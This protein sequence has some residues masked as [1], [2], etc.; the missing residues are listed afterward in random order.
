MQTFGEAAE[1]DPARGQVIDDGEDVLGVAPES[2]QLPDGKDVALA[3]VVEAGIEMWPGRGR[4]ADVV[5]EDAL[6]AGLEEGIDLELGIL[7]GVDTLL[8]DD[9]HYQPLVS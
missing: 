6:R 1:S 7:V 5:G 4:A 9:R 2:V 8:T 3:E